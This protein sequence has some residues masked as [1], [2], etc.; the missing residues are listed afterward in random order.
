MKEMY[1]WRCGM[2][3]PMLDDDECDWLHAAARMFPN[4]ERNGVLPAPT[5]HWWERP[6]DPACVAYFHLT[7]LAE[8]NPN[9]LGHHLIS[10]YGPPCEECGKP[11]RTKRAKRCLYCG[12]ELS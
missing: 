5:N 3:V 1:C 12:H 10:S 4:E 7:G 2:D 9:A 6:D 11:L 8:T